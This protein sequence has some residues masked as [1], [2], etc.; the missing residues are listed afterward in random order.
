MAPAVRI[1][2]VVPVCSAPP[3]RSMAETSKSKEKEDSKPEDK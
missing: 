3:R 1:R 2:S